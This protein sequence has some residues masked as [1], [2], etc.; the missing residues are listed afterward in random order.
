VA[1]QN[2]KIGPQ[3]FV[4]DFEDHEI[5]IERGQRFSRPKQ[6]ILPESKQLFNYSIN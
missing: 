6:R 4:F 1:L 3:N 2:F 5:Q